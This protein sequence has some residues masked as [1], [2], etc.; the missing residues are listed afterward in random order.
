MDLRSYMRTILN[1]L[2]TPKVK[3]PMCEICDSD[4]SLEVHH[5][6]QFIEILTESLKALNLECKDTKD[7]TIEEMKNIKALIMGKHILEVDATTLCEDC[8]QDL[9]NK[10]EQKK[11]L[12][13]Y[14]KLINAEKARHMINK[15]VVTFLNKKLFKNEQKE[16]KKLLNNLPIK[17]D[18]HRNGKFGINVINSYFKNNKIYYNIKS[19]QE[20]AGKYRGKRYWV[21]TKSI[22]N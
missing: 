11:S 22:I 18:N 4:D 16:L 9:H 21:I 6:Q 7:Y 2:W 15:G 12:H 3:K 14:K 19:I 8:H 10:N 20:T 17:V 13:D 5:E 1:N